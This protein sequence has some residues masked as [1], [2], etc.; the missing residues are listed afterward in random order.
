MVDLIS[1]YTPVAFFAHPGNLASPGRQLLDRVISGRVFDKLLRQLQKQN[2]RCGGFHNPTSG[3]AA[4]L[5][6][7]LR[8]PHTRKDLLQLTK[9]SPES[10]RSDED[11][12]RSLA[13]GWMIGNLVTWFEADF[14]KRFAQFCHERRNAQTLHEMGEDYEEDARRHT[15]KALAHLD[16][17][18]SRSVDG[19]VR[20]AG[21]SLQRD[22][23]LRAPRLVA[24][25][26][27]H[28]LGLRP[29]MT[30]RHA[31]YLC[32]W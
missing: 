21:W 32:G 30:E 14:N 23:G 8:D 2:R 13:V 27:T 25:L 5:L 26:V 19:I 20:Y 3:M 29:K 15:R 17:A 12:A 7:C 11:C 10:F 1:D 22:F 6:G 9:V 4:K 24:K 16:A 18:R 28:A 31:R